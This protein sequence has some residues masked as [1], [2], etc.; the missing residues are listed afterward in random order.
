MKSIAFIDTEVEPRSGKVLDIGS[1]KGDGSS[2]HKASVT[3]FVRFLDGTQYICGHNILKHDIRFIGKALSDAGVSGFNSI[4]T[5]YLSPLLFPTKPYHA[6]LKDDKLQTEETN[7]P[8]ND[9]IKAKDL[10][11]DEIAAFH[12]A[13]EVLR[14]IFYLL[15]ND[16][17]EFGAFFRFIGYSCEWRDLD[18]LIRQKFENQIC[19]QVDL[20]RIIAEHPI[21]L[22]YC[23]SLIDSFIHHKEIHSITPPWV[24][25]N[26]R[27]V[28]RI[29]FLLRNKPCVTGCAYCNNGGFQGRK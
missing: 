2:F 7:N 15:L 8:L 9:S 27:E 19:D 24:L 21:E 3:E 28:E 4:D 25:K 16:K 1:V 18:K 12:Q 13:D 11:N 6:L 23:L 29:M 26:Y 22:A 5:L 10:L 20:R 14:Q 17:K